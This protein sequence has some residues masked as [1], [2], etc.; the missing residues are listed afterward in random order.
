MRPIVPYL[1]GIAA[2]T[3]LCRPGYLLQR[4]VERIYHLW[5]GEMAVR[6]FQL[7]ASGSYVVREVRRRRA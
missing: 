6:K 2:T 4:L 1:K 5:G 7:R 3:H